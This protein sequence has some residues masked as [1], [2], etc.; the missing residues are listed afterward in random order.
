MANKHSFKSPAAPVALTTLQAPEAK[1]KE[2]PKKSKASK[3]TPEKNVQKR[4]RGKQPEPGKK[5][6]MTKTEKPVKPYESTDYGKAKKAFAE[7][8]LVLL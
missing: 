1:S 4:I 8:F 6:K 5:P 7:T 3:K 2:K